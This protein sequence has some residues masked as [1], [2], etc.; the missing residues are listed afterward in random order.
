MLCIL[1]ILVTMSDKN[2][3][4]C[5][6]SDVG[7][8]NTMARLCEILVIQKMISGGIYRSQ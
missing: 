6:L 3:D 8:D 5:A 1:T 2:G 4:V 7:V